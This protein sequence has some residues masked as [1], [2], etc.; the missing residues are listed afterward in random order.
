MTYDQG[1]YQL[2]PAEWETI[3]AHSKLHITKREASDY[4]RSI[5]WQRGDVIRVAHQTFHFAAWVVAQPSQ[6]GDKYIFRIPNKER[7]ILTLVAN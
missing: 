5:G 2:H 4:A 3:A 6:D 1:Y 7:N